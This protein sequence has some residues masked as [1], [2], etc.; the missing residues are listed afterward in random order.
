METATGLLLLK[1]TLTPALIGALSLAAR[2]FGHSVGGWLVGLPL[3]SGP[4]SVFLALEQG[5]AFAQSAAAGM[6]AGVL[7]VAAFGLLYAYASFRLGWASSLGVALAGFGIAASGLARLPLPLLPIFGATVA[8]LVVAYVVLPRPGVAKVG[9]A[10]PVWDI[11]ARMVV[12]TLVVLLLTGLAGALGPAWTGVLSPFPVFTSVLGA[13]THRHSGPE[14]A[15]ILLRGLMLGLFS[16][17]TF[18]LVVGL[19]LERL[20][21]ATTYSLAAAAAVVVNGLTWLIVARGRPEVPVP[22]PE[23]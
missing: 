12:A 2:R 8:A 16:F 1:V 9:E 21:A 18:F 11:P 7:A 3:T 10:T 14:A 19:L 23:E 17:V 22:S 13:F 6:I 4:V 20:G 15:R 5:E